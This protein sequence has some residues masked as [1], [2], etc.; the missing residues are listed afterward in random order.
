[1]QRI[2]PGEVLYQIVEAVL[3]SNRAILPPSHISTKTL[4][5]LTRVS[6]EISLRAIEL[7]RERCLYID[8]NK[9]IA[10][11]LLCIPELVPSIRTRFCLRSITSLYLSPF[12]GDTL[13]DLPTALWVREFFY[14]VCRTLRRLVVNM[15]FESLELLDDHLDVRRTLRQGFE[16]LDKLEEFVCLGDYPVLG[17]QDSPTEVW[18]LWPN[19]KRLT[20]FGAPV[21]NHWLWWYIASHHNL[22][23]VI[24]A[25]SLGVETINIKEEY[26]HKLPRDDV[27]LDRDIK[28]T[29]LD[30]AF[31]WRD[32]K[33]SRWNEYDPK[34]RMTVELYDVP[35]S[36]YGD[37][38][39]RELVTTWVK[40]GAL[41][42]SLWDWKGKVV[43]GPAE[44]D[45]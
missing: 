41:E 45:S 31:V 22:E 16:R 29:L 11:L 36:F 7:L 8:S 1:M 42:G 30:A 17:I 18:G 37:E 25:R 23:Q 34:G 20:I 44:N 4:L 39:P 24:L 13:N 33:T 40:R 27:R 28:I 5:S 21:D 43:N 12:V 32:V 2:L 38:T 9:K 26:F 3:P 19:L 10:Q 6:R 14:Q 35:T 15:P